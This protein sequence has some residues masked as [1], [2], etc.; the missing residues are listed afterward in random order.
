MKIIKT[1]QLEGIIVKRAKTAKK[2][3]KT[4]KA[5]DTV[6]WRGHDGRDHKATVLR[7]PV[8]TNDGGRMVDLTVEFKNPLSGQ[9][10]YVVLYQ[11]LRSKA[12]KKG[13]WRWASK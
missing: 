11:V 9:K 1:P 13:M 10:N 4:P 2:K 6:L 3:L 8:I 5:G 12:A 7:V